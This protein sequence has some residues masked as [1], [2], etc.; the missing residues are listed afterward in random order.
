MWNIYSMRDFSDGSKTSEATISLD[1]CSVF[2][3]EL[4]AK[5]QDSSS[6]NWG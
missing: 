1:D 4:V 2:Q 6:G 3:A 5:R